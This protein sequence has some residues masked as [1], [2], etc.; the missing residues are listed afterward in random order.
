M[1]GGEN[2]NINQG[3]RIGVGVNAIVA[4]FGISSDQL[5]NSGR[6]FSFQK[7]D[8]L[9]MRMNPNEG[10]TAE[11]LINNYPEEELER[12]FLEYGEEKY[13]RRIARGIAEERKTKTIRTTS[14]LVSIILRS[15]PENYKH[16]KINSATKVFQAIR[17][18]VNREL[19]NIR[20]FIPQAIEFLDK[21]GRLA[22]ITFH[23]G[24]DRIAK[25][26]FRENARGCICPA[27]FPVCRCGIAPKIKIINKK[28]IL[29]TD[30][31]IGKNPPSRSAKLRIIEKI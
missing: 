23:S 28:P 12:I 16:K 13:A 3:N 25:E 20:K 15:V 30:G 31:E 6:G 27:N 2:N 14:D 18:E 22:V 5:E 7:D 17:I 24:E 21:N 4:D 11:E 9:D 29:P 8:K 1:G 26:I 19:E 10:R